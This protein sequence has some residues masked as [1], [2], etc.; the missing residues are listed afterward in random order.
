VTTFDRETTVAPGVRV[1]RV[2][3]HTAG[4]AIVLVDTAEGTV[5]LSSDAV[6]YVEELDRDRPF[7]H[8]DSVPD[9]YEALDR[10]RRL[11]ASGE[12]VRLVPGHDP[13][14]F[15]DPAWQPVAELP[16]HA[17]RLVLLAAAAA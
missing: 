13:G 4:Q 7:V 9:M 6:H 14:V 15:D 17:R 3:G 8:V 1:V 5:L 11:L 16:E 10:V 2:G 12:A